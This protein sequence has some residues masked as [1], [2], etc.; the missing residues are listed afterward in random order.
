MTAVVFVWGTFSARLTRSDV[1]G[2]IVF[3]GVGMLIAATTPLDAHTGTESVTVLTEATLVWVLFSDASRIGLRELRTDAG[4]YGRLLG[5]GLPLTV[6]AG[7]V[8]AWWLLDAPVWSALLIGAA[9]APTDAALG[10]I[11]ITHPAVPARIRRLLNVESGLN[12]GIVTP[13]VLVALAGVA[14]AGGHGGSGMLDAVVQL[15]VGVAVGAAVGT[16]GGWLMRTA[17]ARGWVQEGFAGPAVL[18]LALSSYAAAGASHGNG[19]VAAFAGGIAF[20]HMAGDRGPRGAF[21]VEQTAGLAS[22]LVWTLVGAVAVP[23]LYG[24]LDWSVAGYAV[25]SLTVVRIIPV[26]LSLAGSGLGR[27]TVLFVAWFGPRGLAS[28]VFSLLA[29]EELGAAG[30]PVVVVIVSTILMSVLAHG[31]TAGPL[32][33]RYGAGAPPDRPPLREPAHTARLS[34]RVRDSARPP[35]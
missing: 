2:P 1:T 22:L 7:A 27:R 11:V 6:A 30:T 10:A 29:V 26:A 12:D 34:W 18:A 23:L 20:G 5:V 9:L 4:L 13:I 8:C 19:F 17:G 28:V 21:Y 25:L 14:T 15:A 3:V 16:A 32:A 35:A 31:V 33:A 24:R